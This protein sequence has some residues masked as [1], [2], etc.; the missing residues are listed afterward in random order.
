MESKEFGLVLAQ[1]L[2]DIEDLHYGWWLED[3]QPSLGT[4][5]AAQERYSQK[6]IQ[7][8]DQSLLG[9][10]GRILDVGCGTG[11][12]MAKLLN[13]GHQVDAVIPAPWLELRVH[14][15]LEELKSSYPA[16]VYACTFEDLDQP[17][18]RQSY[19]L[20]LF[21]E[22]YQYIDLEA[23]FAQ[24]KAYLKP[25]GKVLICDFFKTEHHGDGQSGDK[26]FGGGHEL[27][28]FYQSL[29]KQPFQV[30]TDQ[31]ITPFTS[32]SIALLDQI[33]SQRI[34]PAMD[35]LNLYLSARKPWLF[36]LVKFLLR[37]K[38]KRLHYKYRQGHRS[39]AVF[40]KYKSYRLL[41]LAHQAKS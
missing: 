11:H 32:P 39:A 2:L 19:D 40:S 10:K 7:C 4:L 5:K 37:K 12:L 38:L 14:Q 28:R 31:D 3:E 29:A 17:S 35:T 41:V 36:G 30:L 13:A 25:G 20:I 22:S 33:L 34:G 23:G 8:I 1:Q 16:Q 9:K 26:S 6:L 27:Q 24:I 15:R 18:E 21:S